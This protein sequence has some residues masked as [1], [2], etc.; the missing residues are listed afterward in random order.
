MTDIK[1]AS[2]QQLEN[3]GRIAAQR[4]KS[5]DVVGLGSGKAAL[6]FVRA[7]ADRVRNE[8]LQIIGVPT[9][10]LTASVAK[11]GGIRLAT[12]DTVRQIDV[13]VDGADEVTP[14]LNLLK[15]GGGNLL[16]EKVIASISHSLIIVVGEEKLTP[17][18]GERFP[19][20]VEVVQ[21]ALP[22]VQRRLLAM[23]AVSA[24]PR[25]DACGGMF[26]T[27]NGNPLLHAFFPPDHPAMQNLDALE[28]AIHAIPGA[29]ETGLF[30]GYASE[31]I[32]AMLDG[33]VDS[34]TRAG[35]RKLKPAS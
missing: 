24:E 33:S 9:S 34:L 16:R 4:I 32:V 17:R 30:A 27:D 29:V 13:D 3:I 22:V 8:G 11:D 10:E 1:A 18:L 28:S 23:G 12:L 26:L 20:F 5:G 14:Q 25:K 7:L 2:A 35:R 15:G 31:A 6:A 21:F 19:I